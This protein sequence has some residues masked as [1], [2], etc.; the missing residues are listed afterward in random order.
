FPVVNDVLLFT[1]LGAVANSARVGWEGARLVEGGGMFARLFEGSGTVGRFYDLI[2]S[3]AGRNLIEMRKP[4]LVSRMLVGSRGS[5]AVKWGGDA[6]AA[7][8]DLTPVVASK[9]IMQT[10]M[11][12]GFA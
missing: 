12:L 7:W 11:R 2:G 9:Q 8:R 5:G 3:G 1:G 10:G 6:L 4:S